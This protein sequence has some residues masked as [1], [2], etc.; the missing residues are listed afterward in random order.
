MLAGRRPFVGET[1]VETM[2]AILKHEPRRIEEVSAQ[3]DQIV[4]HCLEKEPRG[5]YQ[6]A[7]DLAFQLRVVRHPSSRPPEPASS[8][9]PRPRVALSIAGLILLTAAAT[10]TWW[11]T[12][13]GPREVTAQFTR[14][15]FDSG[16]TTGRTGLRVCAISDLVT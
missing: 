14:L 1:N 3:V 7:R 12:R 10:L 5:R 4:R 6:S 8:A 2:T 11:L 16:L 15:T 9:A 13:P